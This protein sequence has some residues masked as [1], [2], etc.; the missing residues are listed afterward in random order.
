MRITAI[1]LGS[2]LALQAGAA[3]LPAAPPP[4]VKGAV[5]NHECV[6]EPSMVVSVGSPVDGV[7]ER[8]AVDRGGV[9]RKG[10]VVAALQAGVETAAVALSRSHT[11]FDARKIERNEALFGK[12]LISAQERDEMVT[13]AKLHNGELKKDLEYLKLRTIISPING[14][15]VERRLGPGE[16]IRADKSV[17]LK[18]A[19]LDPLN[20][21]VITPSALFGKIRAGTIGTVSLAPFAAGEHKARVVVVDKLIDPA[22]GTFWVR[23][24]LP[25]PGNKIPSGINCHVQFSQ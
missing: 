20:I 10:Q 4:P 14:V 15:V 7:L 21:E 24:Q 3:P 6:V 18:L 9:V 17:V 16:L 19:Q 25:N 8:V 1:V 13:E 23:L 5:T 2:V 12:Q 11:E 22:S